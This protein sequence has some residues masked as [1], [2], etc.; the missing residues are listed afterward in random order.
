MLDTHSTLDRVLFEERERISESSSCDPRDELESFLLC[1]DFLLFA[2]ELEACDDVF[3]RDFPKVESECTRTYGLRNLLDLSRREDEFHM[4]RRFFE[5]LEERIKCS[6]R[7]HMDLVDDVDFIFS[8]IGFESGLFDE[9]TDIL[10]AVIARSVDLDTVEHRPRVESPTIL[11]CMTGIP[12]LQI[13]TIDSLS[14]DTSA[15]CFSCSTR[16]MKEVGMIHSIS[17]EAISEDGRDVILSDDTVPIMG[18]VG[19]IE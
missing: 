17:S 15:G 5:R 8:L 13:S 3:F 16:S 14:E 4:R 19:S 7:E 12:I 11:T 6:R 10:D 18:A 1:Y 9:I 2:D